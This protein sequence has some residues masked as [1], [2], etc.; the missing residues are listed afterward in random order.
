MTTPTQP[1][2]VTLL[3]TNGGPRIRKTRSGPA[4]LIKDGGLTVLVDCG[5]GTTRRLSDADVELAE[6]D[7]I[8]ITHNHSDHNVELGALL[9]LAWAGGRSTPMRVYG[10]APIRDIVDHHLAAHAFDIDIRIEDEGRPNLRDLIE[11]VE[12]DEEGEVPG[13]V[14]P[15]RFARVNHPPIVDAFAFRFDLTDLSV[16]LSGDTTP[17]PSL[18]E[19]AQGCDILIHE[20]LYTPFLAEMGRRLPSATRMVEHL[21]DS[22]TDA[23]DLGGIAQ[24][25]GVRHLVLNHLVP[26]TADV[27]DQQWLDRVGTVEGVRVTLGQDLLTLT[28]TETTPGGGQ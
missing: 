25:A 10:P 20:A 28:A 6:I 15:A 26:G 3:G 8:Y 21:R 2:E 1:T 9:L 24:A 12:L 27:S 19:L 18:V 4:N 16:T 13:S 23:A 22:H 5:P 11:V 17:I 7:A 14:L